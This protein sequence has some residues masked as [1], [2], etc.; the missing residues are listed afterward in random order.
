MTTTDYCIDSDLIDAAI[1]AVEEKLSSFG[2]SMDEYSWCDAS[3]DFTSIIRAI[4]VRE[5]K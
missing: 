3:N 4:Q 1:T 2:L 5:D